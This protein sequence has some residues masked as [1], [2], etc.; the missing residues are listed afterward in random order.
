MN[1]HLIGNLCYDYV[2]VLKPNSLYLDYE[3]SQPGSIA[4][5]YREIKKYYLCNIEVTGEVGGDWQG[6]E[7]ENLLGRNL[8]FRPGEETMQC[9]M[10][11]KDGGRSTYLVDGVGKDLYKPILSDCKLTQEPYLRG[12]KLSTKY[13]WTHIAYLDWLPHI[14]EELL[15][16]IREKTTILSCDLCFMK[17]TDEARERIIRLSKFFDYIFVSGEADIHA[18]NFKS[19]F[20]I[21]HTPFGSYLWQYDSISQTSK[22]R[23]SYLFEKKNFVNTVGAGDVFA[24]HFIMLIDIP[25]ISEIDRKIPII[26]N[27]VEEYLVNLNT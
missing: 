12:N 8:Y 25:L 11:C 6:D 5:L 16:H 1:L 13:D 23:S 26:H 18:A 15:T 2:K 21:S 19:T 22:I 4:N 24:S 14:N 9:H 10:I 3:Y 7:C 17:Y 20:T 27:C